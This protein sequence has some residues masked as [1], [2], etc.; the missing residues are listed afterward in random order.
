MKDIIKEQQKLIVDSLKPLIT[1]NYALLDI[2]NHTNIGDNLIWAGELEFLEK[3]IPHKCAYSANVWNYRAS[4]IEH[5]DTILFHGGG[6]WGDLYREC[7]EFRLDVCKRF[8]NKRIIVF[9]QTVCYLD[10]KLLKSDNGI[11]NQHP[12]LYVC[13]RDQVSYDMLKNSNVTYHLLLLPDMAFFLG[14]TQKTEKT[15]RNLLLSR[16]DN[17]RK[18]DISVH[19][20]NKI[21][22][23]DWPTFSNNQFLHK[24]NNKLFE[25]KNRLSVIFQKSKL[26]SWIVDPVYGL[27]NRK[28]REIYIQKGV[29]FLNKYDRIYTTRLHGLILGTLLGK[30]IY[31]LDNKYGK[32]MNYYNTWLTE[33][34][35]IHLMIK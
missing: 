34:K 13:A 21:D 7:Q 17:E 24:V 14:F 1:T 12:D 31:I 5:V 26:T 6:N 16:I 28:N 23:M 22:I 19:S 33:F 18:S 3:N 2:P 4:E 30:D 15:N 29:E 10:E 11:L 32:C 8:K 20:D 27:N 35:N 9:P 25:F